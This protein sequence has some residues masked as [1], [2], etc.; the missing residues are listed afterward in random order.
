MV[1]VHLLFYFFTCLIG[2]IILGKTAG[3]LVTAVSRLGVF[4]RLSQFLTGFIILGIATSI[5][6]TGIAVNSIL[7]GNPQLSLGNLFGATIVLLSLIAGGTAV[8]HPNAII[9]D[10]LAHPDRILHI[11]VLILSPLILLLDSRLTR[12][13][14]VFLILLYIG[15]LLY[16]YKLR[17]PD[18]P[19][20]DENLLNQKFLNTVF[21]TLVGLIG[22]VLSSRAVL[23]SSLRLATLLRIPPLVIGTLFLSLGTNIPEIS[24]AIAAI[25]GRHTNL[26]IGDILGSAAANTFIIS[27]L[28][29]FSPF[30]VNSQIQIEIS[31]IFMVFSLVLFLVFTHSKNRLSYLEGIVLIT[32]YVAFVTAQISSLTLFK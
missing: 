1:P 29:I 7:S 11:A 21:L 15:Y 6:E 22:V 3:Y 19:P 16:V 9:R 17:P 23:F 31:A 18:S 27:L 14:G 5:P 24:V 13:D 30:V 10:E 25:R 20:L 12:L 26:V 8:F 32:L 4:L 28:A 2:L